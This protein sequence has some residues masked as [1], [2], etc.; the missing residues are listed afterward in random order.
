LALRAA[1]A[2]PPPSI[3]LIMADQVRLD[4]HTQL[5]PHRFPFPLTPHLD[6]IASEGA[7][8]TR[9]YSSTPVC[10][11]ARLALLTGR[12]SWRHGMRSYQPSIPALN[13]S[14][15]E[16]V[17]TLAANGYHTVS[18]G[19]NHF[20]L[21]R[22]TGEWASHGFSEQRLHEGLLMCDVRSPL[23]A[24]RDH[25]NTFFASACPGCDPLAE[26]PGSNASGWRSEQASGASPYNSWRGY[27]HPYRERLHPTRW[28]ADAAI[29]VLE[30]WL[31]SREKGLTS[32]PIFLKVSFHR[33]HAPYDPPQRWVDRLRPHVDRLP[34]PV[35]SGNWARKWAGTAHNLSSDSKGP[36]SPPPSLPTLPTRA[37]CSG[38]ARRTGPSCTARLATWCGGH[39]GYQSF[40]GKLSHRDA[41]ETRLLYFASMAFVDEQAGRVLDRLRS[42]PSLFFNSFVMYTSDHG[43]ALGDHHLWRKG[44]PYENVASIPLYL[45]WPQAMEGDVKIPRGSNLSHL[46]ELRDVFPT[47]AEVARISLPTD[48]SG[49]DGSSLLPLLG[50]GGEVE[51]RKHLILELAECNFDGEAFGINWVS[52]TDGRMK[53]IWFLDSGEEQMFDLQ[54]DPKEEWDL[55]LQQGSAG[56][57]SEWRSLLALE[58][59]KEGRGSEWTSNG[60]LP[61]QAHRNQCS[62]FQFSPHWIGDA[63]SQARDQ[64]ST[65]AAACEVNETTPSPTFDKSSPPSASAAASPLPHSAYPNIVLVLTD[66]QD[67]MLG[68][69]IPTLGATPMPHTKRLLAEQGAVATNFF[70]HSP[71]C[72]PSRAQLLTG[73]YLHNLKVD[74]RRLDSMP[75]GGNCMHVNVTGR[76]HNFTFAK[77][78]QRVGYTVGCFGKWLNQVHDWNAV[79]PGFDAWFVNGGG[80]RGASP[81]LALDYIAPRF[82]ARHLSHLGIHDGVWKGGV[83]DY[84]TAVI[85]NVSLAWLSDVATG[86][87]PFFAY[88]APKAAH[89]PFTPAPWYRD[90]WDPSWPSREPITPN[91]NCSKQQRAAHHSPIAHNPMITERAASVITGT[92]RNR[93]RTLMSVDDV[94][95][96]AVRACEAAGVEQRT[97]FALSSD[98]GFQLGQLN[99]LMDKRQVYDW[100]TRIPLIFRGPGI[101]AGSVLRHAATLVDLA[102]T[103]LGLAGVEQPAEMDGRSLV[104]LLV[105]ASD[106]NVPLVVRTHLRMEGGQSSQLLW[107]EGVLIEHL[108][109]SENIKCVANCTSCAECRRE[110][111]DINCISPDVERACWATAGASWVGY[112]TSCSSECYPTET[113][114]NNFIALRHIGRGEFGDSLYA[115]FQT[116]E[117]DMGEVD[118][119]RPPSFVE[120]FNVTRDPWQMQNLRSATSRFQQTIRDRLHTSLACTG[121]SCL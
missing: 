89:E 118:F 116:G 115:E 38:E 53:Y 41:V 4:A 8:F 97:Y 6:R 113:V 20:G 34:P 5:P 47:L 31:S 55:T 35:G 17:S 119:S 19:K 69:G 45:R 96:S 33:P 25:F 10:T 23:F 86:E 71:I 110:S 102:P 32:Q 100:N 72:C 62:S 66:D 59:E 67:L 73:K 40:C 11:P 29:R 85:G 7:R 84:S 43:D 80:V 18:V 109:V 1:F 14:R 88:I 121:K 2:S 28:T 103:W 52:L 22:G 42:A 39:C 107:R 15:L 99:I 44:Y 37:G 92:F 21:D 87:R 65:S 77:W 74:P 81:E 36:S 82:H 13:A 98:H 60:S 75:S 9:A 120:F 101:P 50:G 16:L 57:L 90:H 79:P 58:F 91:W 27:V 68:G 64:L 48:G 111:R 93:W 106:R 51:W 3:L 104:P 70:A 49:P 76:V 117:Q 105:N 46:I 108:F 30:N 94:V 78:L 83:N 95:L 26:R 56:L 12:S 112:P 54:S 63:A 61:L 114:D 24:A